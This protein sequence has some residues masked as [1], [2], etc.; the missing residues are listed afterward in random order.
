MIRLK[1]R[2]G[3]DASQ[4]QDSSE[5]SILTQLASMLQQQQHTEAGGGRCVG[6]KQAVPMQ[7]TRLECVLAAEYQVRDMST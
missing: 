2:S 5:A 3:A 6:P 1:A 7:D 4:S